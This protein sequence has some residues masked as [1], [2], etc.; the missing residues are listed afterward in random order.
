MCRSFIGSP[1]IQYTFKAAAISAVQRAECDQNVERNVLDAADCILF[2]LLNIDRLFCTV[3]A[4]SDE[5]S[6]VSFT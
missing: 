5:K 4:I 2:I 1:P 3:R 6:L